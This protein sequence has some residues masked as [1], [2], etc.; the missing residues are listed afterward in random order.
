MLIYITFFVSVATRQEHEVLLYEYKAGSSLARWLVASSYLILNMTSR[1]SERAC[2]RGMGERIRDYDIF[3]QSARG[4]FRKCCYCGRFVKILC[5]ISS[6]YFF[7][8][9]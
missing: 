6:L 1:L 4:M 7:L 5:N 9:R 8:K 3:F 2:K